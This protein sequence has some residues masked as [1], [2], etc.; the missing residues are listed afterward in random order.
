MRIVTLAVL[1]GIPALAWAA[2]EPVAEL[3]RAFVAPPPDA[4]PWVYWFWLNGNITRAGITADL[5]AMKRAGI[6]GALIMEVDQGTPVGPVDFAGPRWRELFRHVC[7][8]ADRLGLE[9]NMNDDAGW[10]GSGGPWIT[11]EQSMQEVVWTETEVEGPKSFEGVLARPEAVAGYY[12]DIAVLACPSVGADRLPGFQTR[13]GAQ[14]RDREQAVRPGAGTPKAVERGRIVN[15]SA[16]MGADGRL[17]W[18]V[19]AG[20]WTILRIGHTSTGMQNAPAP[21][22]GRGLECDK[23]SREGIEAQFAGLMAKLVADS[24]PLAGKALVASHIDSW[25]NGSQNWTARMREEFRARRGYDLEPFLPALTGRVVDSVAITERFLW[26]FRRT[27]SDLVIENYAGRFR[28]LAH[29]HGLRFTAEAYGSPCDYLPYAGQADEPMGEFW[30]GGN[31]LETCRGMASAAHTY[32]KPIVGAEAFTANDAERWRAY[33]GSIKA[34][35]DQAL[36][37]G[38]NRFVFHRYALQPWTS[39]DRKPGMTMGPWGLHYERTQT[40]WDLSNPWHEYL[41][42]CQYLLRQG[43]FVADVCYLQAESSP[44]GFQNHRRHGYDW[45]ECSADIVLNRMTVHDG[46][47]VLPDGMTY[48]LLVLPGTSTMTPALVG[49][50]KE[51][52]EAGATVV[53]PRPRTSPSLADYPRCDAEVDR[54]AR[55][56]WGDCD[57]QAVQE[58][59]WGKGRVIWGVTPERILKRDG[60]PTDFASTDRLR[61]IHRAAEGVDL[62]FVANPL[63]QAVQATASFRVS[64]RE[65]E[66]WWPDSGRIGRAPVYEAS[67]GITHVL[68]PLGPSGSVF[69]VFRKP[70]GTPDPLV[71]CLRDGKPVARVEPADAIPIVVRRAV[72]GILD[73][74]KRSLDVRAKV[75]AMVDAG[76]RDIRVAQLADGNDPA[77][78]V[79]KTLIVEYAVGDKPLTIRGRDGDTIHLTHEAVRIVVNK[80]IYGVLD[81]PKRTRDVRE[82]VQRIADGGEGT[83][84]VTRLAEG[85]DPAVLI[86]KTVVLDYTKDG[87][88]FHVTA[89]DADTID[90]TTPAPE[91]ER[92]VRLACGARGD[93]E[94]EA[95]QAGTYELRA[96]SGRSRRVEVPSVP[97]PVDVA[98]PW[99]VTFP[100]GWGAPARITLDSLVSWSEHPDP[101]VR[102]FSGTASYTRTLSVP[103][104]WLGPGKGLELDLGQV[105]VMARVT[106]NGRDLGILWKPPYR[107]DVTPAARPGENALEVKVVNLWINRLIGDELLPED[108]ERNPNGTLKAWPGWLQDGQPSPTGR[109]TF[110]TWRLWKKGDAPVPS[111]LIGPVRLMPSVRFEVP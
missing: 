109:H 70:P 79:V 76:D 88:P 4:R 82:R 99:Q 71:A 59:R 75:Q 14:R 24:K 5:E 44:Q 37:E 85:D 41:A 51:L 81:D 86:V 106:L 69:V 35:G 67:N 49:R 53:G 2:A 39:P 47:L 80:A 42:R 57:G 12:R 26:D 23:L 61:A 25:E 13:S 55:E 105:Q 11:P 10:N 3:E 84:A 90:L 27:I 107:L 46:R 56:T 91:A 34:L 36:C 40:W 58:H 19:P 96:A 48:R 78:G 77:Y 50:V 45:D 68:L 21:A 33:P 66:L 74:P 8:E 22:S 32:G 38:I 6:G 43:Q 60:V 110:T 20:A 7:A 29:E 94:L 52:V 102:S 62:Y 100:P 97:A 9:I 15:L 103:A 54:L 31:A 18:D 1:L 17:A 65:P 72:Y 87:K 63:P 95:W 28:Q 111:G 89:T 101:G 93:V 73:D 64:G 16:R 98:G 83:F 30:I 108:S 104:D 92:V